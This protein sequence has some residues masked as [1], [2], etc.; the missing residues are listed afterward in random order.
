MKK[1]ISFVLSLVMML[2]L[3][4]SVF[5][6]KNTR[7]VK[8]ISDY[9]QD[10]IVYDMGSGWNLGNQL[11]A[12]NNDGIPNETNWGNPV[13]TKELI[14]LVKKSGFNTIRIPVSYFLRIG[15]GPD[16]IIEKAW[17]DRIQ[18]VVDYAYSQDMYII[19]N[20]HGDGYYTINN[21]WILLGDYDDIKDGSES[22]LA[23]EQERIDNMVDKF[24]KVW[25]QIANR[26]ADYDEHLIFE[27]M[28]EMQSKQ[29]GSAYAKVFYPVLNRLNQTFVDTVRQAEGKYNS[30]RWLEIPGWFTGF[31]TILND[32]FGFKVPTDN[33]RSSEIPSD[34]KRIMIA[35]HFYEPSNFCLGSVS[36]YTTWGT[37]KDKRNINEKFKAVSEKFV[38]QGYPIVIGEYGSVNK[39]AADP[40][41]PAY[42][43]AMYKEICSKAL[44]Y[45]LVPVCWD[46]GYVNTGDPFGLFDR[47]NCTV[48][49]PEIVAAATGV[50]SKENIALDKFKK[51]LP[52]LNQNEYTAESWKVLQK[53]INN[54]EYSILNS[55]LSE[56]DINTL[57]N[58]VILSIRKLIKKSDAVKTTL[59][60]KTTKPT[61]ARNPQAVKKDKS[62]A[63]KAMKQA[64]LNS[65][66]VKSRAKKKI[67]VS[68]KKVKKAKGYQVQVSEKKNFKKVVF[69]K[70]VKKT[71][72]TIK[73]KKIKSRKKYFVRVRAYTT[74]KDANNKAVKVYSKWNKKLRRVKVK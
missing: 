25:R 31:D 74:Y 29:T 23:K 8:N 50:Y 4:S 43:A 3:T 28:N 66:K 69:K 27:S 13:I 22:S 40:N 21:S 67:N 38:S 41:N 73:N 36:K 1:I 39:E 62:A 2:T 19:L 12:V 5:A 72:L 47:K 54:A 17:L 33:Y 15:E 48:A 59:A 51:R 20:I 16:Y 24:A 9:N 63:V 37:E 53:V 60:V 45:G 34:Q 68:W 70:D 35:V 56:S 49:F 55:N 26:F 57:Y 6:Q 7:E 14:T 52:K 61:A 64:K 32:S 30:K 46:N 71:K 44:E 11:E 18:E 42:R 65:L 58:N 10:K